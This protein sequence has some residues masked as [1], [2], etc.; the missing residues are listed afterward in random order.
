MITSQRAGLHQV[1]GALWVE[2]VDRGYPSIKSLLWKSLILFAQNQDIYQGKQISTG[3]GQRG[4]RLVDRTISSRQPGFS[5]RDGLRPS[6]FF[7]RP[8]IGKEATQDAGYCLCQFVH[9]RGG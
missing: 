1:D 4:G 6:I 7:G 9:T 5:G 3:C 2:V 8:W